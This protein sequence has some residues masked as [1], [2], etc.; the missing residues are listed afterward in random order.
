MLTEQINKLE[1]WFQSHSGT[2]T[3]FSGGIDSTLVLFLSHKFLG[4]KGI[5]CISIS[6]SLK[7]RDYTF[8]IDFCQKQGI[9]L[10]VIE[11]QEIFDEHYNSNPSNRCYF[12][13]NHLYLDL[14]KLKT[15]YPNHTVLNG[16][17][18]DDFGDYRPGLQ[19]ANEYKVRSPLAECGLNKDD[20]RTMALY[21]SLPNWNKPASPCLS[22]RIP[23]GNHITETKLKQVEAAE[24]VLHHYGFSE[25]R[26]RHYDKEARIEVPVHMLEEI[27]AHF[28]PIAAAIKG[29]G[30]EQCTVD[31][32]GFVSGKLNRDLINEE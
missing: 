32:E 13:K 24:E 4:N 23:Y 21:F 25:A 18:T 12:C 17:N 28:E 29:L 31:M 15:Q 2:I 9:H 14:Q 20:I 1:T 11:T 16:T 3:A 22:S 27:Q 10:E 6:P 5:G 30:F 26:V 7:R 8:A 19:A